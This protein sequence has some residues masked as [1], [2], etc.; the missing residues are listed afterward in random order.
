[1][2][3]GYNVFNTILGKV[4][5]AAVKTQSKLTGG[6]IFEFVHTSDDKFMAFN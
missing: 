3:A 1:M 6:R 4:T 5:G 2:D